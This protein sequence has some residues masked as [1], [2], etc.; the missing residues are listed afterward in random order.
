MLKLSRRLRVGLIVSALTALFALFQNMSPFD[1]VDPRKL[2]PPPGSA[3]GQV[4]YLPDRLRG[5]SAEDIGREVLQHNLSQ[6]LDNLENRLE[7]LTTWSSEG[8]SS[9]ESDSGGRAPAGRK[10]R[11]K[12]KA[13]LT[14][15]SG[16]GFVLEKNF[17]VKCE[18]AP[19]SQNLQVSFDQPL[20]ANSHLSM[21]HSSE[22]HQSSVN[23]SYQ[24]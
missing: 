5:R 19:G 20:G 4:D 23:F 16:M 2:T 7:D 24:W 21:K 13:G 8:D 11:Y 22:D 12:L 18:Y 10:S 3:P 14:G 1:G 9:A 17:K 15:R 6:P